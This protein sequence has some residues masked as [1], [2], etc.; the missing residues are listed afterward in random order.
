MVDRK[1]NTDVFF[2]KGTSHKVCQDYAIAGPDYVVVS[3]GCSSEQHTDFGSR[4]LT[5]AAIQHFGLI[6]DHIRWTQTGFDAATTN[7]ASKVI[8]RAADAAHALYLDDRCLYATLLYIQASQNTFFCAMFGDGA[9]VLKDKQGN[10][11]IKK[12]S[13]PQSCPFYL[14]Y[15]LSLESWNDYK[16]NVGLGYTVDSY[17]ILP[18]GQVTD[19]EVESPKLSLDPLQPIY[20]GGTFMT[21]E[22]ECAA[23]MSD[24][25][26]DFLVKDDQG[27]PPIHVNSSAII[28]EAMSFKGYQGE[29]VWRRMNR[30]FKLFEEKG[31][32]PFDD[33]SMGVIAL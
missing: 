19:Q 28:Q 17:K 8:R 23:V 5:R 30:A 1:M 22:W 20:Y 26:F 21:N 6:G 27:A 13:F 2:T 32:R 33:F 25:A 11:F 16:V 9:L 3:D 14:R 12:V 15:C 31:W 29:F 10:L 7:F 24:G 4:L 18:D